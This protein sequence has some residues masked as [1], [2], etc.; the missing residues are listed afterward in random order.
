MDTAEKILKSET[1]NIRLCVKIWKKGH[2]NKNI[3]MMSW[4]TIKRCNKILT[5][6][7]NRW[8]NFRKLSEKCL[9]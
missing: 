3:G 1:E 5:R 9:L 8:S 6:C 2:R 4:G 7:E